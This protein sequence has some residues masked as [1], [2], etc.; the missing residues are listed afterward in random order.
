MSK[1]TNA[2]RTASEK[3]AGSEKPELDAEILSAAF[4]GLALKWLVRPEDPEFTQICFDGL[5]TAAVSRG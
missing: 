2:P 3:A 5:V 1:K 4:Q